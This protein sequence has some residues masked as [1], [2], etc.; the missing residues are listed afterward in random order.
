MT[1]AKLKEDLG[2]LIF[3]A[4]GDGRVR[5]KDTAQAAL[6]R[7]NELESILQD[8]EKCERG[9]AAEVLNKYRDVAARAKA[10]LKTKE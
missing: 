6:D 8:L 3:W 5:W 10:A 2:D 9:C 7:I 1:D 4:K